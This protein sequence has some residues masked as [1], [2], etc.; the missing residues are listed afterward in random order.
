MHEKKPKVSV[1]EAS[2]LTGL[3]IQTIRTGLQS[4]IVLI[5]RNIFSL[6]TTIM[7]L[8]NKVD[9]DTIRLL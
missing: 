3:E 5:Y 8:S 1:G 9:N 7:S 4:G 6:L 2:R